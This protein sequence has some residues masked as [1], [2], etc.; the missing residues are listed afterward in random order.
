M[1]SYKTRHGLLLVKP[2]E[3]SSDLPLPAIWHTVVQEYAWH[4][5]NKEGFVMPFDPI[6]SCVKLELVGSSDNQDV[7]NVLHYKYP[8]SAPNSSTLLTF[9]DAWRT[10]HQAN[11]M[12][13][14]G[15]GYTFTEIKATDI[16]APGGAFAVR[17][18]TPG[19]VGTSG[20]QMLPNN[21][22]IAISWRTGLTG[23]SNRG[24][25][26]I[27]GLHSGDVANNTA[28]GPFLADLT[29]FATQ[30]VATLI[31]GYDFGVASHKDNAI[32][33]VTG[34]ILEAIM[35]SM[36]RRLPQRGT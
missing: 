16:A 29:A 31:T 5:S 28:S 10:A 33:I 25:S 6:P 4:Q 35:D 27:G 23:R 2:I 21:V 20:A 24:R 32:K 14:H 30:L 3:H 17:A 9:V 26:F 11:Y 13:L 19:T 1:S 8:G 34:F 15:A 22:A 18:I 36:R 12:A 7:V